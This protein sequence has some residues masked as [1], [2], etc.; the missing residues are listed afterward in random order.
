MSARVFVSV[1]VLLAVTGTARAAGGGPLNI[2]TSA[3]GV[4]VPG[5]A[6]R[7][8]SVPVDH[9]T[10]LLRSRVHGGQ[11]TGSRLLHGRIGIP[12]VAMDGTPGGLS[13]DGSRL[14]LVNPI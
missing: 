6:V 8:A 11:V 10:M 12:E 13:A 9:N 3:A 14:V 4:S 7:F 1:L 2:E 5:A